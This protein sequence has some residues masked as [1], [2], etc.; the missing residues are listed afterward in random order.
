MAGHHDLRCFWLP[1]TKLR[2]VGE[3][4][5]PT[6]MSGTYNYSI[7]GVCKTTY[8]WGGPTLY[9]ISHDV[10]HLW[11]HQNPF[12]IHQSWIH[13]FMEDH[14]IFLGDFPLAIPFWKMDYWEIQ[15][16]LL[17]L[18]P[19]NRW[20]KVQ[21]CQGLCKSYVREYPHKIWPY[22]VQYLHFRIL[23][24]PFSSFF[25]PSHP[26]FSLVPCDLIFAGHHR[27]RAEILLETQR[28]CRMKP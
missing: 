8:N 2:L 27:N 12:A 1:L 10:S 26:I 11:G 14:R 17:F 4:I 28:Y 23:E 18:P 9:G 5:T 15:A 21:G 25:S 24:L 7:H 19:L 3:D 13:G 16:F 6:I 22:M 20:L